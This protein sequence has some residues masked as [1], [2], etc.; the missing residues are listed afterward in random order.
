MVRQSKILKI[1][2]IPKFHFQLAEKAKEKFERWS[3][4]VKF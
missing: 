3:D 1:S 4:K 2:L